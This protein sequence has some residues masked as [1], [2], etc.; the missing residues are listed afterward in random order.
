MTKGKGKGACSGILLRG[1]LIVSM[2]PAQEPF[3]GDIL[4]EGKRIAK[5]GRELRVEN[6]E[7]IDCS[8]KVIVPGLIQT[9]VHLAQ[10]LFRGL[11]E[12]RSLLEW[13]REYIYPLE[14]AHTPES[15]YWSAMLGLVELV[16]SGTTA[17]IDI[18][19]VLYPDVLLTAMKESGLRGYSGKMLMDKA[20]GQTPDRLVQ[21]RDE[22]L[23]E[24]AGLFDRFHGIDDGRVRVHLAP[25]FSLACSDELQAELGA[26]AQRYDTIIHTHA[27]ET[28]D[29][30]D[31]AIRVKNMRNIIYL[32]SLGLLGPRSSLV[33]C[34]W[35]ND[36]ETELLSRSGTNLV[37]CPSAN[38]KLSS[39]IAPVERYR[40]AGI[41]VSIGSDGAP[42]NN[43]HDI[44]AELKLVSL[45]QKY[46]VGPEALPA[47]EALKLATV[48][49][50]ETLLMA[51]EVGVIEEGR[52]ADLTLLSLDDK[53]HAMPSEGVDIFTRL[54][55]EA[56]GS[57]VTDV[58]V[59]GRQLL[60][61]GEVTFTDERT[62]IRNAEKELAQL[63]MRAGLKK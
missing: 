27:A 28:R 56:K 10:V 36:E 39:G 48:H 21:S 17:I 31:Y 30:N 35:V 43:T 7:V 54:V 44:F 15:L 20:D 62:V 13:L 1:G 61:D 11:A 33:H 14:S 32:N 55:Y 12:G 5:V 57:D 42:C 41:N 46:L 49:G 63:L 3:R 37:T 47:Q 38:L 45:L 24:L 2:R 9:H 19:S 26:L 6:A 22:I 53:P 40:R 60:R 51:E 8:D 34:I 4:I 59:D 23:A 58:F 16:K 18:G 50:A 52:R 25:R 29:E